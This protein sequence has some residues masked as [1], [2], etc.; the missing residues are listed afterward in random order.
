MNLDHVLP[1]FIAEAGELLDSME[2]SLLSL[3]QAPATP[4]LVNEIFRAAHTIKGSAGIFGFDPI[5]SFTHVAETVLDHARAG[6]VTFDTDLV[7]LLLHCGDHI[8]RLVETIAENRGEASPELLAEGEPLLQKLATYTPSAGAAPVPA[9]APAPVVVEAE[10]E[11]PATLSGG[12]DDAWLIALRCNRDLLRGGTSPLSL[13]RY[14]RKL[15]TITEIITSW[16]DMPDIDSMDPE[17]CYL[18][19]DIALRSEVSKE[20][21]QAVFEFVEDECTVD[22]LKPR[23]RI[24]EYMRLIEEMPDT[25]A[26]LGDMLVRCG[27]VTASELDDALSA[28]LESGVARLGEILIDRR[29]VHPE[30]IAAAIQK[31]ERIKAARQRVAQAKANE[32]A[33][34]AE[35]LERPADGGTVR[36]DADKL[37]RLINLVGELITATASANLIARKAQNTELQESTANLTGLVEEVRDSALQLRMVRI[38]ATFNR[39]QRVVHEVSR[40][41]GKD[42]VLKVSGEDAELDKTVVEKLTDPL[43]HLVR[44]A[45]DHGIEP[46]SVRK[47]KGKPERGTV[48]LNAFHDSGSIVIEVSDDGGGL[49]RDRIL[50]KAH[51]RGLVDPSQTL[52]DAEIFNLI[53]EPG[54][55]TAEKVTNLSGRGVGMDV[56]KRNITALRGTISLRSEESIGTTMTVRLPLTLAIID[57]FLVR[58]GKAH[59]VVPL[60]QV[61]ECVEVEAVPGRDYMNLRG[62][63]LP[64]LSLR[65]VFDLPG[66]DGQRLFAVVV[67]Q[68]GRKVG[69]VVDELLGEF[70]TV[71]KPLGKVFQQLRGISGSTILGS[72]EIALIL[73]TPALIEQARHQPMAVNLQQAPA[74]DHGNNLSY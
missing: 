65:R 71:I 4:E 45:M 29:I 22:I 33:A 70:Q 7:D 31:Q 27:V 18:D 68:T 5:V 40:E 12:A 44:N 11:D 67:R 56:V 6:R 59:Y 1:T 21:I 41:L 50:A 43:T 30:V 28:Q 23:S 69:L 73:D 42:I 51:E 17:S 66:R 60:D 47:Q 54:F 35:R 53:F 74:V 72:G 10:A 14:L 2:Q 46:A 37:D 32:L 24:S 16:K 3:N 9:P 13:I 58:L 39:F 55:S 62:E 64:L 19:F 49:R 15:G 25:E 61:D 48:S 36:V 34:A 38:G 52:D 63:V 57:G 20:D 26:R 8:R